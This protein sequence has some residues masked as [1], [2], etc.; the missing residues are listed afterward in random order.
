VHAFGR[1]FE[2]AATGPNRPDVFGCVAPDGPLSQDGL[3][4]IVDDIVGN[5][6]FRHSSE[7]DRTVAKR[8]KAH[9]LHGKVN[10]ARELGD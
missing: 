5:G 8:S 1:F 6:S 10:P 7:P 4:P 2:S 9:L 3:Q